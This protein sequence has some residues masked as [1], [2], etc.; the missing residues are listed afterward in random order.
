MAKPI[1]NRINSIEQWR[2]FSNRI[3]DNLGDPADVVLTDAPNNT[4]VNYS[5]GNDTYTHPSD[6]INAI[7]VQINNLIF[8]K[9]KRSGD[10]ISGS[11]NIVQ[12]LGVGGNTTLGNASNDNITINGL[13][14]TIPN[15]LN[16]D[17][18]SLYIDSTNKKIGIFQAPSGAAQFQVT[19]NS[20][21]TGTLEVTSS[22]QIDGNL[23]VRGGS[24]T[25]NQTTFNILPANATTVNFSSSAVVLNMGN[26]T[27]S[28]VINVGVA[29]TAAST[30]NL[31]TGPVAATIKTINLGTNIGA[32]GISNVN[33][34]AANG[35]TTI[36]SP[37]TIAPM[38]AGSVLSTSGIVIRANTSDL[39]TGRVNI[40]T[41]VDNDGTA[42][43]AAL[44]VDGGFAV[45]KKM[46]VGSD[47][48]FKTSIT[49][50]GTGSVSVTLTGT[51]T[52]SPTST[53]TLGTVGQTTTLL[54]NVVGSTSNQTISLT[55]SGASGTVSIAPVTLT[56]TINNMSVG[57]TVRSTGAFTLLTANDT[58]TLTK[59]AA[60]SS[61][62]TG[63]LQVTGG[64]GFTGALYSV[65]VFS[66]TISSIGTAGNGNITISGI[67][68]GNVQ[69]ADDLVVTGIVTVST[70]DIVLSSGGDVIQTITSGVAASTANVF[71]TS[72]TS[73]LN[74]GDNATINVGNSLLNTTFRGPTIHSGIATFN[75]NISQVGAY[76]TSTGT[77]NISLNGK[78]VTTIQMSSDA[79]VTD[80]ETYSAKG[81]TASA[82]LTSILTIPYATY[83]AAEVVVQAYDATSGTRQLTKLLIAYN[84]T[85]TAITEYGTVIAGASQIATYST[86]VNGANIRLLVTPKTANSIVY[87]MAVHRILN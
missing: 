21:L 78:V 2:T 22:G 70:G 24:F 12:N 48:L 54:G 38:I 51:V 34:G 3:S 56:G 72:N 15:S 42:L 63:T 17:S 13:T 33:I 10:T 59:N 20:V 57:A 5:N 67:G 36:V 37:T 69:I 14:V 85:D 87:K 68:T 31:G 44:V 32:S 41:T 40:T 75:N 53:V 55:P 79:T 18:N 50:N 47:A 1:I 30:Y 25:T 61:T 8:N 26:T 76:T 80:V 83:S 45:A 35:T 49:A 73:I 6:E 46:Y 65:G 60:A 71:T 58:T 84:G 11:L 27:A 77:G 86:D 64:A 16:I 81:A 28:Q 43:V 23:E 4:G 39:T 62:T 74:I 9:V 29:S 7:V 82:S 66:D 19:G 52:L